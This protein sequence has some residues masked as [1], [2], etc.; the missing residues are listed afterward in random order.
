MTTCDDDDDGDQGGT[1]I[2]LIGRV[3]LNCEEFDC[4]QKHPKVL[5]KPGGD[6]RGVSVQHHHEGAQ[7]GG[8]R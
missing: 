3:I 5:P 1:S 7:G 8:R 4:E 6:P 2:F